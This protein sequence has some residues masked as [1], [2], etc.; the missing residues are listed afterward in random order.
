MK[1]LLIT[2]IAFLCSCTTSNKIDT[3]LK[4]IEIATAQNI[5]SIYFDCIEHPNY[6]DSHPQSWSI[7]NK[8]EINIGIQ[9]YID[10]LKQMKSY[11]SQKNYK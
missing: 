7:Y 6:V 4:N 11:Q 2:L 10:S 5:Q 8:D 1:Y 9:H 3:N